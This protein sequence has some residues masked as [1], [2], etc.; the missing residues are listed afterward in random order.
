[1]AFQTADGFWEWLPAPE[2]DTDAQTITINM[3][4]FTDISNVKGIQLRPPDK[5]IAPGDTVILIPRICYE[6]KVIFGNTSSANPHGY[7]C[8]TDIGEDLA[9]LVPPDKISNWSVN[10]IPG[11]NA[12]VGTVV[13]EQHQPDPH[14]VSDYR[15]IYTAPD[16]APT[17]NTVAVS[18]EVEMGD[19]SKTLIVSNITIAFPK[20]Y[21]GDLSFEIAPVGQGITITGKAQITWNL[22]EELSTVRRYLPSGSINATILSQDCKPLS[23]T[24][25]IESGSPKYPIGTLTMYSGVSPYADHYWFGFNGGGPIILQCGDKTVYLE[26]AA[27]LNVM[28]GSCTSPTDD[29]LPIDSEF[30]LKGN[31]AG[32]GPRGL[33]VSDW[34]FDKVN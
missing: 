6:P 17:P 24:V 14:S 19:G 25:A 15:A 7:V 18:A 13:A 8:N 30:H 20:T 11:G 4:H 29:L 22:F 1:M 9:P 26:A 3:S 28:V 21:K 27:L 16:I 5:I 32:C 12:T 31:N 33:T 2:I 23:V 34:T 10:G